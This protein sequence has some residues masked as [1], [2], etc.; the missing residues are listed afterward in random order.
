MSHQSVK[1]LK[2]L[3]I[4]TNKYFKTPSNSNKSNIKKIVENWVYSPNGVINGHD[5]LYIV[6]IEKFNSV[7]AYWTPK[8]NS[9]SKYR[10]T[11]GISALDLNIQVDAVS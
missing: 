7:Q 4:K 11:P 1:D 3:E 2:E 9:H 6:I 8:L 5:T 10:R